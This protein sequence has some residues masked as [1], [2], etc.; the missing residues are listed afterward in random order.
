MQKP[1]G[2]SRRSARSVLRKANLAAFGSSSTRMAAVTAAV[3]HC[4]QAMVDSTVTVCS[5]FSA[6][7]S[8]VRRGWLY[9][10]KVVMKLSLS[11]V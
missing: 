4:W 9:T 1:S 10:M 3:S 11:K 5:S 2:S 7:K 8:S 6:S